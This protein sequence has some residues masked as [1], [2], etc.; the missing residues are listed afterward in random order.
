MD[1][2]ST[3]PASV[4]NDVVFFGR[5]GQNKTGNYQVTQ[6]GLVAVNKAS[7]AIIKDYTLDTNFHGGIAIQNKYV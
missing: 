4:V 5:T 2:H 6:G 1:A 3:V 7:G